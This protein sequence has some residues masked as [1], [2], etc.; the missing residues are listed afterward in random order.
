MEHK[1]KT[2]IIIACI[3]AITYIIGMGLNIGYKEYV[4][5]AELKI[6]NIQRNLLTEC[7]ETTK[8]NNNDLWNRNCKAN[9]L[10]DDCSLDL[11]VAESIQKDY[12]K[13]RKEC[14][15]KF[16]NKAFEDIK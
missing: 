3:V 9:G 8:K 15:E 5:Q 4:R 6:E 2:Y 13:D 1:Y 11:K 12:E 10:K 14:M 7:L 16:K